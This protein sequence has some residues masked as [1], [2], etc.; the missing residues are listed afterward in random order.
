MLNFFLEDFKVNSD[1]E[2][3][4]SE[5]LSKK[6]KLLKN[7][8]SNTTVSL[9]NKDKEKVS[10]H[11]TPAQIYKIIVSKWSLILNKKKTEIKKINNLKI[12]LL[13]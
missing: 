2:L 1:W 7:S 13:L 12:K 10:V 11:L 6:E 5:E 3:V 9:S 8:V 4:G